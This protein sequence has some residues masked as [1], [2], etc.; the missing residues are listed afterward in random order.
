MSNEQTTLRTFHCDYCDRD[1][2]KEEQE[3]LVNDAGSKL[4]DPIPKHLCEECRSS[5]GPFHIGTREITYN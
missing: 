1:L 4:K 3:Y 2:K 5:R